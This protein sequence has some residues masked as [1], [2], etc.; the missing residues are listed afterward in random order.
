MNLTLNP[1]TDRRPLSE[2]VADAVLEWVLDQRLRPG[3]RLPTEP[4]LIDMFGVSR[5]VV[6]EASR[7]LIARGVVDVRP[8]RGMTVASF[9]QRNLARQVSLIMRLGGGTFD[10][11][12]EMRA[13]MEP[14]MTSLAATR[15]SAEDV[16]RLDDLVARIDPSH[17]LATPE[18]RR[19]HI[20]ADLG[21]HLAI[22]QATGNP[23][24][25][26]T[27]SSF[28]EIL[29]DTYTRSSGY[30]PERTKTHGEH[31]AIAR[32][33]AAGKAEEAGRLATEH[34]NRVSDAAMILTDTMPSDES[35]V[36]DAPHPEEPR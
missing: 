29:L 3:D 21:F 16:E 13:S 17:E 35:P 22:A 15:R 14:E 7:T 25:I 18:D 33:V 4:E 20:D 28:N 9:D 36:T 31:L 27:T 5:T 6:R 32:A 10:Q 8:R 34:I 23:F 19:A 26:H 24:F 12:M 30:A 2:Q 1:S 11:L